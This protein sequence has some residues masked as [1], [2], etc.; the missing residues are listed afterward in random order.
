M[1]SEDDNYESDDS[2][3]KDK[4]D[5]YECF[6]CGYDCVERPAFGGNCPKCGAHMEEGYF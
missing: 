3:I 4:P 1:Y 2:E 5:Y 6:C